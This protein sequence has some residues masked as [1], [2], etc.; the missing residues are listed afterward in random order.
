MHTLASGK[1]SYDKR[2]NT[3]IT[4]LNT[5]IRHTH[6][7]KVSSFGSSGCRR[8]RTSNFRTRTAGWVERL[9]SGMTSWLGVISHALVANGIVMRVLAERRYE[10]ATGQQRG[11]MSVATT[12]AGCGFLSL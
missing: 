2:N 4:L 1:S 11:T 12:V 8:P 10:L 9:N 3:R 7:E 5:N 6:N